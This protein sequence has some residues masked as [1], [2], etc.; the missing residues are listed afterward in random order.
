MFDSVKTEPTSLCF[1]FDIYLM[2]VEITYW[3]VNNL[4]KL[5]LNWSIS[6]FLFNMILSK[7]LQMEISLPRALRTAT[8]K[9]DGQSK[10]NSINYVD[11]VHD[12][13]NLNRIN[14]KLEG[15]KLFLEAVTSSDDTTS[16]YSKQFK[17]PKGTDTDRM[18]YRIDETKHS[19]VVEAPIRA[20]WKISN[21]LASSTLITQALA[22]MT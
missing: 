19:L 2:I 9:Q 11:A 16:T 7:R 3:I 21:N 17:L 12:G 1:N 20:I 15:L 14:L 18:S 6:Y 4:L 13:D 5:Y 8:L 22:L 10:K